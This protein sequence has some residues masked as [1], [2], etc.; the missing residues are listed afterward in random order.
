MKIIKTSHD[1]A[2]VFTTK[3]DAKAQQQISTFVS[4]KA[5][6]GS[7]VRIMPDVHAGAGCVIG[8]TAKLIDKVV[9]NIV[10]VDIGCGM[11]VTNLGKIEIN[12]KELDSYIR[13]SI[14]HGFAVNKKPTI[15][16]PKGLQ[17]RVKEVSER[18]GSSYERD[19]KSAGTLGGGNH[20]I[21]IAKGKDKNKY[22][23]IHSGSRN[24]GLKVAEYHQKK[25]KH[26]CEGLTKNNILPKEL[27]Y[28]TGED[29]SNYL[30]DMQVAIEFADFSR[31]IMSKKIVGFLQLNY[32]DLDKFTTI[33]N[34]I[35]LKDKII[36][37][38]AISAHNNEKVIIPLNMRDGSLIAIGKGNENWNYSAPHGAGRVLSRKAAK[39][40]LSLDKFKH[41]MR[42]VFTTSISKKTLDESPMAYKGINQIT[43]F[44][45]E[46]IQ[47]VDQIKPIYNFKAN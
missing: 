11:Q 33:H 16:W 44:I 26:I 46:T 45:T 20:F 8:F 14:P 31:K 3:I 34:Y 13:K 1:E 18:I 36:R 27:A 30:H 43:D 4:Q 6:K 29:M 39:E 22:L 35:N 21:E 5:F 47:I 7:H 38:G 10:G 12:F 28:L 42:N 37:K 17:Q 25:A 24:F 9:P 23:V 2:I 40:K 32:S 15:E 41:E 19:L